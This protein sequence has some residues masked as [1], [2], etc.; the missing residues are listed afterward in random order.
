MF[1]FFFLLFILLFSKRFIA[2]IQH[3]GSGEG[4]KKACQ[5][6]QMAAGGFESLKEYLAAHPQDMEWTDFYAAHLEMLVRIMLAQ[7]Q[8]CFYEKASKDDLSPAVVSKL[9]AQVA[10]F[11]SQAGALLEQEPLRSLGLPSSWLNHAQLRVQYFRAAAAFRSSLQ[12]PPLHEYGRQLAYL[13]LAN[14][15]LTNASTKRLL[16]AAPA[17]MQA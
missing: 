8:E 1:F 5:Y 2:S 4:M 14:D 3:R 16:K 11:Y 13:Q 6:F 9:A 10:E 12:F 7:A 17:E 15:Y